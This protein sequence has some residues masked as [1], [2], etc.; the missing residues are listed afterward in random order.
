MM[1]KLMTIICI[2]VIASYCEL[3]LYALTVGDK[4]KEINSRWRNTEH[5]QVCYNTIDKRNEKLLKILIFCYPND[6]NFSN[7]LPIL[8]SL[9]EYDNVKIALVADNEKDVTLFLENNPNFEFPITADRRSSALYMANSL[10][11]PKAFIINYQNKIIWDGE[12]LD[13]IDAVKK[14]NS[15]N[16][17]QAKAIKIAKA[18]DQLQSAMRSGDEFKSAAVVDEILKLDPI[19]SPALRMRL[20]MLEEQGRFREAYELLLRQKNKADESGKLYLLM[21]DLMT[22]YEDLVN[23]LPILSKELAAANNAATPDKLSFAWVLL[24]SFNY[25]VD[26]VNGCNQVL[27]SININKLDKVELPFYYTVYAG[28]YYKLGKLNQAIEYQKKSLELIKNPQ[29]EKILN[30]YLQVLNMNVHE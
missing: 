5:F 11:F 9:K 22:R 4:A 3:P 23:N 2:A 6:D 7:L 29:A 8:Y 24:N 27:K 12:L 20:F 14:I 21:L 10:I 26:A 15:G 1:K 19:N 18:L 16:F 13:I 28:Y 17:D 30:Y 25:N